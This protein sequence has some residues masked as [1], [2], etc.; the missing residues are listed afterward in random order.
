MNTLH[1]EN[2]QTAQVLA[3]MFVAL[4]NMRTSLSMQMEVIH[5][6][7]QVLVQEQQV[8]PAEIMLRL[9]AQQQKHH[10]PVERVVYAEHSGV[11][12]NLL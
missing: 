8:N 7:V 10:L 2:V 11:V 3:Q 12:E 6:P 4:V 5:A 1:I 9:H